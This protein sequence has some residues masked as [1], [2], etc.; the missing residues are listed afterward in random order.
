M[1]SGGQDQTM[2]IVFDNDD[3]PSVYL[4]HGTWSDLSVLSMY[5]DSSRLSS[6]PESSAIWSLYVPVDG[7][8]QV[9]AWWPKQPEYSTSV[10]Y[11]V[12]HRNGHSE[13]RMDQRQTGDEWIRL[14]LFA[15]DRG[16]DNNVR[17]VCPGGG[18]AGADA[19]RLVY[20][21][22]PD[23]DSDG[24]GFSDGNELVA[25]T[26]PTDS[27]ELFVIRSTQS[28]PDGDGMV[29]RWDTVSGRTYSVFSHTDLATPWPADPVYQVNGDGS[30]KAY[31][32]SAPDG[33]RFFRI[34][35][36]SLD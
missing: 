32:N 16:S 24:D 1:I 15:F 21:S 33:L 11:V 14:G 22:R 8:Y 9:D 6:S 23:S 17:V 10:P 18:Q 36:E 28:I 19:I 26:S 34:G 20:F 4:E 35:V 7:L 5:G 30:Q 2:G 31:T 25:G 3:G 13:I 27:R 29:F 12:A